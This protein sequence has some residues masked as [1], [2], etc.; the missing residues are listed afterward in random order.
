LEIV[1]STHP[2]ANTRLGTKH[3]ALLFISIF[4]IMIGVIFVSFM[5]L[6]SPSV[7]PSSGPTNEFSA[8]RALTH[9][10]QF[11]VKPH[12]LGSVEKE[13]VRDYL[14][15]QLEEL[16][17]ET[18]IQRVHS[19]RDFGWISGGQVENI[20][21]KIE[22]SNSTKAVMLVAHYDSVPGSPGVTDDGA[23]VAGI[24]ETVRILKAGEPLQN[25]VIILLTDGEE[26]GL[27]GADAFVKNHPWVDDV[28]LV[29]NYEARGHEGP[30]FLF[31]TSDHNG[32]IVKEFVE[33]APTPV[34]HSFIY[35]LYKLLPNDTDMT[36]FKGADLNGLN[37]AI[38]EGLGHYHT[39]SDNLEELSLDSLQHHGEYMISLIRHFGEVDLTKEGEDSQVFFNIVGSMMITYSENFTIPIMVLVVLLFVVT[40]L[41]AY[42]RKVLSPLGTL[43]GF[44]VSLG[45]LIGSFL[46]G[47]GSWF[48]LTKVL[49]QRAWMMSNDILFSEMYLVSFIFIVFAF[50]AFLY[51][52]THKKVQGGSLTMGAFFVWLLLV[53]ITSFLLKGGSYVF[54]WPLFFAMI[55]FNLYLRLKDREWAGYL[56]YTGFLIPAILI[57]APVIYLVHVLVTIQMASI[58]MVIVSLIAMLFVPIF[59]SLKIKT[60]WGIPSILLTIGIIVLL[61]NSLNIVNTPSEEHHQAS[62]VTYFLDM[63]T[64]KAYWAARHGVDEHSANYL[65]ENVKEGNTSEF[66]PILNWKVSYSEAEVYDLKGPTVT[67]LQNKVEGDKRQIEY[68]ITKNRE[69]EEIMM[70]SLSAMTLHQFSINGKEVELSRNEYTKENG[71][72]MSYVIGQDNELTIDIT[73]NAADKIEW[74]LADRSYS[75]PEIKG[76]RASKFSTYGDNSFILT[77]IKD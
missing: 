70:K 49:S 12:P 53:V 33:A 8:E 24:L 35:N 45:A 29:L 47:L 25:D 37:F 64:N 19:V 59:S 48:L 50:I 11:A 22:G 5:Q 9:L 71:F 21:A 46:I 41:H 62:D 76:E 60:S 26:N 10:E 13:R 51:S 74:A 20:V 15:L 68:R 65:S 43:A 34:A 23:A 66:N 69:A 7:V 39:T 54:V 75:I 67:V 3:S 16:G 18:E 2:K 55:G 38:G 27:L 30:S 44:G 1:T 28:G 63:D 73:V 77:T 36:V 61:Y 57:L 40:S 52:I 42:K 17:V 56:T 72:L 32:W 6:Q 4:A 14:V 31:E 58:L